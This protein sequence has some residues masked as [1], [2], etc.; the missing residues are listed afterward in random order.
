MCHIYLHSIRLTN[1]SRGL[2]PSFAN[3]L[4]RSPDDPFTNNLTMT[5]KNFANYLHRDKDKIACVYG[6]WWPSYVFKRGRHTSYEFDDNVEHDAIEGGAFLW[7]EYGYG[8]DFER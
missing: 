3:G 7:G 1:L 2:I 4:D 8:V 6:M 5:H